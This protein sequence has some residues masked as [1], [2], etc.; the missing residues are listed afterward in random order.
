MTVFAKVTC[1][2]W[3]KKIGGNN[4]MKKCL[5]VVDFQNDFVSGSLGFPGAV[6]LE[7]HIARKIKQYRD[8][9]DEV[10]FTFDTHEKE[11]LNTQEGR[12]L[13]V[14]H[15][16]EGTEGHKLYGLVAELVLESDKKFRKNTFGSDALYQYLKTEKFKSIEF[17]GLVSNI[18]VIANMI[19]AKTAQPE[20]PIIIETICT[21]SHDSRLHQA[22][23]DVMSSLQIEVI[24]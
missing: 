16:I 21:A 24:R 18:C 14:P 7:R 22:A 4:E 9:A 6:E 12:K 1:F 10:I 23:L 17:A 3:H 15:C 19:L 20:T 8:N 13:P 5:I 2:R 11:Y